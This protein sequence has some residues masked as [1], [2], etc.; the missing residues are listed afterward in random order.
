MKDFLMK[1]TLGGCGATF[2]V[3]V[4][5][6]ILTGEGMGNPCPESA[7]DTL[8]NLSDSELVMLGKPTPES[9]LDMGFC[10][11]CSKLSLVI[12]FDFVTL[13]LDDVDEEDED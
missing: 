2:L 5:T 12:D 11:C 4:V 9:A 6:A 7:L 10:C 8:D 3:G 13:V 1:S